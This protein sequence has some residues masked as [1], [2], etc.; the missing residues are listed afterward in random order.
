MNN[1]TELT[2]KNQE[3]VHIATNQLIKDGKNDTEIKEILETIIPTILENQKK[4]YTARHLYGAPTAWAAG[5]SKPATAA[6][7]A[8]QE[9][10][11]TNPWLM[12]LDTSLLFLALF[13]GMNGILGFFKQAT[14]NYGII[15]LFVLAFAGGGA[16]YATYYYIYRH[17][18]APDRSQVPSL[19]KRL[20]ILLVISLGWVAIF[21]L[22]TLIPASINLAAPAIPALIIAVVAFGIKFY[23]QR[24]YNIL[25]TM[26]PM[27]GR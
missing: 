11:N 23:L 24:K 21:S 8:N 16:M 26:A 22:S 12:W 5:F 17:M 7:M 4:G 18:N 19:W 3:F 25:N 10:K 9:A 2:K 13:A 1:L 27:N 20:G 6:N 14:V 15:S